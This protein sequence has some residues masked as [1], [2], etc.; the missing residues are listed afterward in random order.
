MCNVWHCCRITHIMAIA[1]SAPV[2][3]T[4][5]VSPTFYQFISSIKMQSKR[6]LPLSRNA[7][8][9][10]PWA[11]S[12]RYY[13]CAYSSLAVEIVWQKYAQ[14]QKH[15]CNWRRNWFKSWYLILRSPSFY[16]LVIQ[17]DFNAQPSSTLF[18]MKK[19]VVWLAFAAILVVMG[20][21]L[22]SFLSIF[23]S[24]DI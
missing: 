9:W 11:S 18:A 5:L 24:L 16:N 8:E 21:C 23:T 1:V 19:S 20:K 2:K 6:S 17:A 13:A 22:S 15:S 14:A 10:Q 3:R 4:T 12:G 7:C